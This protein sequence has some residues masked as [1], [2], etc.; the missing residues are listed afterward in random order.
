M[1]RVEVYSQS[2]KLQKAI[3]ECLG[4]LGIDLELQ[5][6]DLEVLMTAASP[7]LSSEQPLPLQVMTNSIVV[8]QLPSIYPLRQALMVLGTFFFPF[9]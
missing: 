7:Y 1:F 5:E 8:L 2:Y 9:V 6:E 3:L 4:Q